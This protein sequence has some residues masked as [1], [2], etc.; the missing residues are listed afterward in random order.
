MPEVQLI[1]VNIN[2]TKNILRVTSLKFSN[3]HVTL[4]E[5]M[6]ARGSKDKLFTSSCTHTSQA[7][8]IQ[9]QREIKNCSVRHRPRDG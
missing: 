1:K 5:I 6:K 8:L 9:N 7:T 4:N 2:G 3:N